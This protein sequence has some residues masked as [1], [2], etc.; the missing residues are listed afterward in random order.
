MDITIPQILALVLLRSS[1][2]TYGIVIK[3][4]IIAN[5]H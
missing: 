4:G 1:P 5:Q 2:K 3:S